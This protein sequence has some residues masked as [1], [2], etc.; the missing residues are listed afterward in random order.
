MRSPTKASPAAAALLATLARLRFP[1]VVYAVSRLLDGV[2]LWWLTRDELAMPAPGYE[3]YHVASPTP[4]NPDYWTATTQWDGQWY[5][6]VV[7]DGY[8]V[9]LPHGADGVVERSTWAFYPAYP[10]LVRGL[11]V[12]T[13]MPFEVVAPLTST[14]AGAIAICLLYRLL[15][16]TGG[17]FVARATV[18]GLCTYAAAPVFQVAYPE[19]LALLLVLSCLLLARRGRWRWF[20]VAAVA[21]ALTRPL[22]APLGAA[23]ALSGLVRWPGSTDPRPDGPTRRPLVLAGF[24]AMA[25][26]GLWPGIAGLST[27]QWDAY[28][29]TS[30]AW[31]PGLGTVFPGVVVW[32][33][34]AGVSGIILLIALVAPLLALPLRRGAAAWGD[35]LRGW[36]FAYTGY[37]LAT[38]VPGPSH[39]RYYALVAVWPFVERVPP[40]QRHRRFVTVG[41]AVVGGIL[42]QVLW[43]RYFWRLVGTTP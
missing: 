15:L 5:R 25:L 2:L 31:T 24:G 18:A 40:Q 12:L 10:M 36:M 8:P 29:A 42:A 7:Q 1:L 17:T 3:A 27:G 34:N 32:W 35:G 6:S 30:R 11:M 41:V 19:S 13:R 9:P 28:F 21:L 22:A 20:A 39:V 4:A 43:L 38:T 26:T 33:E 37:L 23:V 14:V 16:E